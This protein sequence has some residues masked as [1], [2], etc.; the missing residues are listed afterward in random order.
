MDYFY[1]ENFFIELIKVYLLDDDTGIYTNTLNL[2][3]EGLL[4]EKKYFTSDSIISNII[5]YLNIAIT[6]DNQTFLIREL[7]IICVLISNVLPNTL[8]NAKA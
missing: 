1:K 5:N 2:L 8:S 7:E 3:K 6:K 4:K